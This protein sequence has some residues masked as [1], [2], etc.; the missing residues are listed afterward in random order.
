MRIVNLVLLAAVFCLGA[1]FSYFNWTPVPLDYLTGQV[2][3]PLVMLLL[4]FFG[5][6]IAF[7]LLLN[8]ARVLGLRREIARL[9][10]QLRENEAELKNLRNI[11]LKDA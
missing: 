1:A 4:G 7:T 8:V 6:G 11:P 3:L 9:R 10:R 5:A 2:E